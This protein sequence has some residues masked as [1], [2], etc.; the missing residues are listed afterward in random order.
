MSK[1]F[2][3][4]IVVKQAVSKI[5]KFGLKSSSSEYLTKAAGADPNSAAPKK[6]KFGVSWKEIRY[7]PKFLSPREKAIIK[8]AVLII[9]LSSG[10]IIYTFLQNNLVIKPKSGGIYTENLVGSPQY[11]NPL[12]APAN[13]VDR[14]L[15]K[16]IFAGLVKFDANRAIVPDLAK[17]WFL[18]QDKKTYTFILRDNVYW[19][20]QKQFTSHDVVFTFQAIKNKDYES[21]LFSQWENIQVKAV[22]D[23]TV[24]F[25]LPQPYEQFLTGLTVGILPAHLW[26]DIAPE[27][28][29]LAEL[30]IKPVGLGPYAFDS[31]IKDKR[32][33]I[34]SYKL[35]AN[36]DYHLHPPY[37]TQII[38]KFYPTFEEAVMSL[39]NHNADG[40]SY[41]PLNLKNELQSRND[42]NYYFLSLPQ[43]VAVFFNQQKNE[44]LQDKRIRQALTLLVNKQKLIQQA[45]DGEAEAIDGP[46]VPGSPGYQPLAEDNQFSE[47]FKQAEKLF[48]QA[49][50]EYKEDEAQT[51]TKSAATNT[52]AV[53]SQKVLVKDGQEL[54]LRLTL[55]NQPQIIKVAELLKQMWQAAGIKLTL[56]IMEISDIQKSVIQ[57]RDFELLLFGEI[58]D[59]TADLY[60]F[61]HSSQAGEN[62]FNL[63]NFKNQQVDE[64][65]TKIR[66]TEDKQKKTDYYIRLN[67]IIKNEYP[68]IF[69]YNPNYTYVVSDKVK[70]ITVKYI[71]TPDDRLNGIE[72]WYIKTKKGF[73]F[74]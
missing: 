56:N 65:L 44:I 22:D 68:A 57:A 30:N 8:A 43:Y 51:D 45:L 61:W 10:W 2:K 33:Y 3:P 70:G 32:G 73:K 50:W 46:L 37:I 6:N 14:D 48:K 7:I 41:L 34:K 12:Y 19:P 72:N 29:K 60:P 59:S 16:L 66:Q 26:E 21:P 9:L 55:P 5:K 62:G 63:S 52:S 18:S 4:F 27:N 11:V 49:G 36:S 1:N 13:E 67:K 20:D 69:L 28:A 53:S 15:S 39:K 40:L 64:L 17:E 54:N 71:I 35:K 38:F 23:F 58:L 25:I 24:Q 42:L 47:R 31:F 74:N